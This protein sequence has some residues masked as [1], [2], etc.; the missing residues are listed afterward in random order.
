MQVNRII[1]SV[2]MMIAWFLAYPYVRGDDIRKS[3][4]NGFMHDIVSEGKM[5]GSFHTSTF[6]T[7][8]KP[9]HIFNAAKCAKNW[10]ASLYHPIFSN[11][12]SAE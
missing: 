6:P 9:E 8:M 7:S 5:D 4:F 11:Q 12:K 2:K 3:R 1:F 10:Q